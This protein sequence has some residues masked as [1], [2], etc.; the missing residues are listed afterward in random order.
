LTIFSEL[1]ADTYAIGTCRRS[2]SRGFTQLYSYLAVYN[3]FTQNLV[4]SISL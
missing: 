3:A 2:P 1:T 4:V